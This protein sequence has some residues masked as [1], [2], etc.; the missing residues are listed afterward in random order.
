MCVSIIIIS[1]DEQEYV[2]SPAVTNLPIAGF[3]VNADK[4]QA[5]QKIEFTDL[6][7][8]SDG[9]ITTW[10]WDFG[11]S[12]TSSDQSPD[13]FYQLGGTYTVK[14]IAVD[15]T[16]SKSEVY[17]KEVIIS[18]DPLAN[19]DAP[20]TV[21][22]FDL[23]GKLNYSNPAVSQNGTV[24]IGFNQAIRENQGPDFFAIKDGAKVWEQ[25]FV[26]GSAQKSDEIRSSP[27]IGPNYIH[28]LIIVEQHL[29]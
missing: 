23:E 6:S 21:W 2:G 9:F 11:D 16:G 29:F 12:Q 27:S 4:Y 3:T 19:I 17:S 22:T 7:E 26:E 1:C 18:D 5:G 8:D 10:E 15:N 25:V 14:L 20:E 28:P 13:H 24:Y